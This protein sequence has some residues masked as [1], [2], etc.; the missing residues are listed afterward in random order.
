MQSRAAAVVVLLGCFV[1]CGLGIICDPDPGTP[2]NTPIGVAKGMY[3]GRVVWQYEPDACTWDGATGYWWEDQYVNL[4]MVESMLLNSLTKLTSTTTAADAWKTLFTYYNKVHS[5]TY[6][7]YD[8]TQ[9]VAVKI[10]LNGDYDG[11]VDIVGNGLSPQ[12]F[13]ALL[14]TL[15]RD[16]GIPQDMIYVYDA[17]RYIPPNLFDGPTG[18]FSEFPDV[19]YVDNAG[20]QGRELVQP[21]PNTVFFFSDTKLS[22]WNVTQ[23]PTIVTA[24]DYM[25]V[26]DNLRG[27]DLAGVTLSAKNWFGSIWRLCCPDPYCGWEVGTECVCNT[28]GHWC[29]ASLHEWVDVSSMPMNSYTPLVD[30]LGHSQLGGNAVVFLMDG[31]YSGPNEQ[32]DTLPCEFQST[33]FNN[34]WSCSVLAS[35]DPVALDSVAFD[36]LRNEPCQ[37]YASSGCVDNYMHEAALAHA[38]PSGTVYNPTGTKQLSSLGVHEHW[39]SNTKRQYTRNLQTGGGIELLEI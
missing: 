30:L 27:H 24:A 32:P 29:P 12:Y 36:I 13:K 15:T 34:H 20:E 18:S 17:A 26:V 9:K 16:A 2:A 38:P 10:N 31:L 37:I 8:K 28:A 11:Y 19:H 35:Q 22:N 7:G 3:P 23:L 6:K 5:N 33:P 14:R 39:N 1:A 4:S 21:D 25:I